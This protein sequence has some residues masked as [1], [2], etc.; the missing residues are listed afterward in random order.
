VPQGYSFKV[1]TNLLKPTAAA[2]HK[3]L[4]S[5]H[6]ERLDLLA[7]LRTAEVG[8]GLE[9]DANDD[10]IPTVKVKRRKRAMADMTGA[11]ATYR[12]FNYK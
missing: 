7:K 12:V 11:D 5:T 8:E 6:K 1:I 10:G 9:K 3:L 2:E 4:L